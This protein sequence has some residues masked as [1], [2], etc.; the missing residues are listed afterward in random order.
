MYR[1]WT[2]VTET[3]NSFDEHNGSSYAAAIGYHAIISLG[4]LLLFSIGLAGRAFGMDAAVDQIVS[5]VGTVAGSAMAE[6][7]AG[8]IEGLG[9]PMANNLL[10]TVLTLITT[11]YFASNVFRQL[12][13]AMDAIWEVQRPQ[14]SMDDGLLRWGFTQFRRYTVGLIAALVII[15]SLLFSMLL[16]VITGSLLE[17]LHYLTPRLATL[18]TLIGAISLPII[19]ILLC[20]LAFKLLPS[21]DLSWRDV[22]P[23][24][25]LTGLILAIG[26]GIIG[27]YASH[28]PI[29]TFFGLAGSLVVIMLWAYFSAFILLIGAE[30]TR[31]YV[32]LYR[33]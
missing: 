16:S 15:I 9:R 21:V 10:L 30:F 24:A 22:W 31:V 13:I 2:L 7:V 32:G 18:L 3:A 20:L 12:V 19:L 5:V 6:L 33:S 17:L 4:P 1:L 23:G 28:N 25:I 26:E 11:L 14:V 8:I 27:W 29:P